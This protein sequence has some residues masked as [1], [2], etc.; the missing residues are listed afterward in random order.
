M[1]ARI[2]SQVRLTDRFLEVEGSYRTYKIHLGSG[3]ILM[4]PNDQYLCIVVSQAKSAEQPQVFLP[5]EEDGLL[6]LILSKA[7]LLAGDAAIA[8]P[9][10]R[11]Q[12]MDSELSLDRQR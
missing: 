7:F 1:G 3:N 4:S 12:I 10:I 9:A 8:D 5:F 2:A 11:S 6:S